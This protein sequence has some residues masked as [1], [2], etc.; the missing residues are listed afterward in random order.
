MT[1]TEHNP[2]NERLEYNVSPS[3]IGPR[4]GMASGSL[5]GGITPTPEQAIVRQY[6]ANAKEVTL[7]QDGIVKETERLQGLIA[8]GR[9][10][11]RL[12]SVIDPSL[13]RTRPKA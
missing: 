12:A 5:S 11:Y 1:T 3:A 7:C 8:E 9:R 13:K 4:S 6:H 2:A 10:L